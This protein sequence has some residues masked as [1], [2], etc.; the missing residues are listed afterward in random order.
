MPQKFDAERWEKSR[1]DRL[2]RAEIQQAKRELASGPAARISKPGAWV[3][4]RNPAGQAV[5]EVF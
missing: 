2:T 5:A 1:R 3:V 4:F